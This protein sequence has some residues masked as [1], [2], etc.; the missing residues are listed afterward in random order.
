MSQRHTLRLY[1]VFKELFSNCQRRLGCDEAFGRRFS[2]PGSHQLVVSKAYGAPEQ[3]G[4]Q[5]VYV[6]PTPDVFV[7]KELSTPPLRLPE[8]AG[9]A[10]FYYL[11]SS[12]VHFGPIP[13]T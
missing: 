13:I 10:V 8:P 3:N 4:V 1:K 2:T 5:Y 11:V 6:A 7:C 9:D 12:G